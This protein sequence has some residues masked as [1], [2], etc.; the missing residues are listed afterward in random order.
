MSDSQ[1]KKT[2]FIDCSFE[3]KD[4]AKKVGARWEFSVKKWYVPENLW[5]ELH[6]FNKWRPNGRIYLNCPFKDKDRAKKKGARWDGN[7]KQWYFVPSKTRCEEDFREWLGQNTITSRDDGGLQR[8]PSPQKKPKVSANST[9]KETKPPEKISSTTTPKKKEK[10]NTKEKSKQ[11]AHTTVSLASLPR[12]NIDMTKPQLQKEC[13]TR[14]PSIKGISSKDKQWLMDYLVIGSVWIS[15]DNMPKVSATAI[16]E[17]AKKRKIQEES[18]KKS[19]SPKKPKLESK[20]PISKTSLSVDV[21]KA[22]PRVTASLTIAELNH[23]LH[24]RDSSVKGTSNK[25]K[26]WFMDRLGIGSVQISSVDAKDYDFQM[27][28]RIS[29]SLTVAQLSRE[30]LERNPSQTGLSGKSKGWFLEKLGVGSLWTTSSNHAA[31]G[32]ATKNSTTGKAQ[33]TKV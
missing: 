25:N 9:M 18:Q 8:T 29:N 19:N 28:P 32:A 5:S 27:M 26:Q 12:I 23:E 33:K 4:A 6:R 1:N 22:L 3:E 10:L 17:S 20:A 11:E 31:V 15:A 13:R 21:L 2:V 24:C 7:V 14:D 16:I 30:V